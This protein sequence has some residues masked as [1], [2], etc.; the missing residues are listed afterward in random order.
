MQEKTMRDHFA[1]MI[2][3]LR[4]APEVVVLGAELGPPASADALAR[5]E[6]WFG[7]HVPDDVRAFY[8]EVGAVQ[9]R[10]M[11]AK[12]PRYVGREDQYLRGAVPWEYALF[13]T[14]ENAKEDGVL[15]LPPLDV[16]L[17]RSWNDFMDGVD[18]WVGG[19]ID[20]GPQVDEGDFDRGVRIFDFSSFYDWPGFFRATGLVGVGTDHGIDWSGERTTFRAHLDDALDEMRGRIEAARRGHTTF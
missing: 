11:A 18:I 10:W 15:I 5:L 4:R 2:D 1:T 12:S 14:I 8:A 19:E 20:E 13:D 7:G 17:E 9:I 3:E 6:A 16:V